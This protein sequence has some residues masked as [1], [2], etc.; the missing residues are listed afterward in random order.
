MSL[1]PKEKEGRKKKKRT[2]KERKESK[3]KQNP[4]RLSAGAWDRWLCWSGGGPLWLGQCQSHPGTESVA[5]HGGAGFGVSPAST[6]GRGAALRS[7][8]CC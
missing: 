6:G 5:R 1:I 2:E 3:Q 4:K 8:T 7:P